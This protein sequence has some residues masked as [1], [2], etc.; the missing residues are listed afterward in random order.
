MKKVF[1]LLAFVLIFSPFL[2]KADIVDP[3][4]K[5]IGYCFEI[6][7]IPDY[8]DYDLILYS[9][10]GGLP[11]KIEAGQCMTFYKLASPKI[12]ALP[13][14]EFTEVNTSVGQP[15]ED[16]FLSNPDLIPADIVIEPYGQE[17]ITSSLEN[18]EDVFTI[19]ELTDQNLEISK[20]KRTYYYKDGSS[21]EEYYQNGQVE[22][23]KIV[24]SAWWYWLLIPFIAAV[25]IVVILVWRDKKKRQ[26]QQ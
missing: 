10:I 2:A 19:S 9:E 16:G 21:Q 4:W 24:S 25:V 17:P 14:G 8:P 11:Q 15:P 5:Q 12:F 6:D 26:Q 23:P 3:G 22:E 18:V 20:V 1:L 7:N 13:A